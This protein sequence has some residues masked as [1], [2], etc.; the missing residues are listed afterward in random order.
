M[1]PQLHT[2]ALGL[3]PDPASPP[4]QASAQGAF[5]GSGPW[6]EQGARWA[7][8]VVHLAS[9][10]ASEEGAGPVLS[11]TGGSLALLSSEVPFT[12]APASSWNG[13]H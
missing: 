9:S 3:S 5:W 2:S 1:C 4:R 7:S 10:W 11:L 6:V 13:K 8:P 12:T